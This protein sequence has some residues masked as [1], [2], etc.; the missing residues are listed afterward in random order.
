MGRPAAAVP[1]ALSICRP[2]L[3]PLPTSAS[4]RPVG[5]GQGCR[6]VGEALGPLAGAAGL[7]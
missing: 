1:S 5:G 7:D 2:R 3:T 6:G 4:A